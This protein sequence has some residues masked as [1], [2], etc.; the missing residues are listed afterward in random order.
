MLGWAVAVIETELLIRTIEKSEVIP[1]LE[2]PAD[3]AGGRWTWAE[4]GSWGEEGRGGVSDARAQF[5][6]GAM[7]LIECL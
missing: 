2:R 4:F 7:R 6:G 1:L 5:L 3:A